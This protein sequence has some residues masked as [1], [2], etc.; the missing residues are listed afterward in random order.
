MSNTVEFD[1]LGVGNAIVDVLAEAEDSFLQ[2]EGITK[3]GMT[4]ID[5]DRAVELYGKMGPGVEMSGGSAAN[6]LAGVASLGGSGAYIGKV[7]DDQLGQVFAHDIRAIGVRYETRPLAEGP[8]TARCLILIT[9]DAQRSMNTFLG[10]STLLDPSDIDADL[11]RAARVTYLE[12]YLFDPPAA[13]QAF[14]LAAEIAHAAGRKVALTLSDSFCVERHHAEFT[15][16]VENV[17]ILFANEG[18][19]RMLTGAHSY[20]EAARALSSACPIV[21]VTHG[22]QGSV[23]FADGVAHQIP[24]HPVERLVD[25]T[26]AGD[27]YAAGVLHGITSGKDIPTS[28]RIGA[29]AAAEIISQVGPRPRRSLRELVAQGLG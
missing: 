29:I 5:S 23:I 3:G 19:A 12:G 11:V 16:L 2:A 28:G 25:T 17:D 4:L 26:G 1:V 27:L 18:E 20:D 21:C 22:A 13:K 9:P 24:A 7:R 14:F 10:A 6:T 8:P 15:R